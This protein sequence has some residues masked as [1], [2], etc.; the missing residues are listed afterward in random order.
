MANAKLEWQSGQ[1]KYSNCLT[2]VKML[3]QYVYVF[4]EVK[5]TNSNS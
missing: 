5:G 4:M 3:K 1:Y 2:N